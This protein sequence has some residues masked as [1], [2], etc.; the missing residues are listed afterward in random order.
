MD[1]MLQYDVADIIEE[2]AG[3]TGQKFQSRTISKIK[4]ICWNLQQELNI[5][6]DQEIAISSILSDLE[7]GKVVLVE[8]TKSYHSSIRYSFWG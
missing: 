1:Y 2:L 6:T 8:R 7:K 3:C 5:K 4:S